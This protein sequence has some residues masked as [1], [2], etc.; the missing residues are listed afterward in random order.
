[1]FSAESRPSDVMMIGFA[2]SASFPLAS[3]GSAAVDFAS[4]VADAK[5]GLATL[6]IGFPTSS[7]KTS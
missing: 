6:D 2:Y 4:F 3:L 1:M 7:P 5:I